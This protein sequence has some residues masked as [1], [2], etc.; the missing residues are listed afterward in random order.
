MV[1]FSTYESLYYFC[2]RDRIDEKQNINVSEKK[3]TNEMRAAESFITRETHIIRKNQN[4][5]IKI[6]KDKREFC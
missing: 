2:K 1:L 5:I 4:K 3:R 6:I